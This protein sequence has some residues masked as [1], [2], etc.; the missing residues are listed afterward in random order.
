MKAR[1]IFF[2]GR[3]TEKRS[4]LCPYIWICCRLNHKTVSENQTKTDNPDWFIHE[5]I[6]PRTTETTLAGASLELASYADA[7]WA[8]HAIFLPHVG[9]E[10][11]VTSPKSVCVGGY[12]RA[13]LAEHGIKTT[14]SKI[15]KP[16]VPS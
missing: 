3:A 9:E 7:L 10:D 2:A 16:N 1:G 6:H 15:S 14:A 4:H 8:R 5:F 11:C 13:N 12:L